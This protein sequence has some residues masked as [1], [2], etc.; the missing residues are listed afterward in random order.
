MKDRFSGRSFFGI[1]KRYIWKGGGA[2]LPS[3]RRTGKLCQCLMIKLFRKWRFVIPAAVAAILAACLLS[4]C[5]PL[6]KVTE[7]DGAMRV[8]LI[9]DSGGIDDKGFN[10]QTYE[11]CRDFCKEHGIPFTYFM[12]DKA[13]RYSYRNVF[14]AAAAAGYNVIV[15]CG[16][17]YAG[18]IG[19]MSRKY[20]EIKYI[21]LDMEAGDLLSQTLGAAYDGDPS[22]YDLKEYLGEGNTYMVTFRED[23]A[24]Y[25]AGYT[26]ASLGYESFGFVGGIE[27]PAVMR[28]GY[29][30]LQGIRDAAKEMGNAENILVRYAY[31]GQFTA[32]AEITAAMETWYR[33]GTEVVFSCGGGIVSSV[34]EAG[35]KSKAKII[36]VDVD[37]KEQLDAFLP[38]FTLTSALKDLGACMRFTLNTIYDGKWD[39]TIGGKQEKLGLASAEDPNLN[40]VG[41]PLESTQWNENF[42][43]EDYKELLEKVLDGTLVSDPATD[44]LPE[45]NFRL[46][47]RAGTIM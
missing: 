7:A 3:L 33:N 44:R 22:H 12:P 16:N 30:F 17:Q 11:A 28:Y 19:E 47:K 41:L 43:V 4:A 40:Y 31:T 6:K 35:A 14:D 20:P 18:S 24:G 8:A 25:L 26:A 37:Q 13:T 9:A 10:Q 34:A 15:C 29:G 39:E 32:S 38:G 27:I 36:G 46:E 21:G 23:I 1:L 45:I 5:G 2:S 42:G